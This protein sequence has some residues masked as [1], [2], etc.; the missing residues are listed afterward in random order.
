MSDDRDG[1]FCERCDE[2]YTLLDGHEPVAYCNECAYVVLE[3]LQAK[4]AAARE[5]ARFCWT[6][7]KM[8]E[9]YRVLAIE[10]WPWLADDA[11]A[12]PTLPDPGLEIAWAQFI[13]SNNHPIITRLQEQLVAAA[14]ENE[15][16]RKKW[17]DALDTVTACLRAAGGSGDMDELQKQLRAAGAKPSYFIKVQV[18]AAEARADKF[19]RCMEEVAS[20]PGRDWLGGQLTLANVLMEDDA[21]RAKQAGGG[22]DQAPN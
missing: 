15:K 22:G 14:A 18:A 3:E 17:T 10:K 16:L 4:L 1:Y 12:E 5:A 9:R 2:E 13:T 11:D 21:E 7:S 8:W 20:M 6:C 19:R